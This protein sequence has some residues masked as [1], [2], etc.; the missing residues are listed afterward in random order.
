M[1]QSLASAVDDLIQ[2]SSQQQTSIEALLEKLVQEEKEHFGKSLQQLDDFI[3]TKEFQEEKVATHE[4]DFKYIDQLPSSSVDFDVVSTLLAGSSLCHTVRLPSQIRYLGHLTNS[5]K[6]GGPSVVGEETY[7]V[8]IELEEAKKM[9]SASLHGLPIA[10]NNKTGE[11]QSECPFVIAPDPKD[12]FYIQH[13]YGWQ[14]L[15]IPND[16]TRSAY[17][18]NPSEMKGVLALI[19][20]GCDWGHCPK[21]F[22]TS[23]FYG[24]D[25]GWNLKVNGVPATNLTMIGNGVIIAH[26]GNGIT[27]PQGPN[28]EYKL[29]FQV[30]K[31]EHYLMMSSAIVF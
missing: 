26:N 21:G 8:G 27:F 18:Y 2:V 23:D 31:P 7:D 28:G 29:E 14:N 3:K 11:R 1:V 9:N 19:L 24:L 30:T 6:V 12:N 20:K 16:A 13:G 15:T 17:Q 4:M 25:E 10:W 22:L 5:D